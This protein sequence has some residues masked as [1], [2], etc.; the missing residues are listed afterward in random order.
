MTSTRRGDDSREPSVH[1]SSDDHDVVSWSRYYWDQN[2][3]P[4][5]DY[6]A[7]FASLGRLEQLA[8][9]AIEQVLKPFGLGLSRYLLLNTLML[10]ED[11]S[12]PMNR[13]SWHMMV[14]PTTVT[15]VVDQLEKN[16]LV[17][18]KPHPTDRRATLVHITPSGKALAR[19]ASIALAEARFGLPELP[20]KDMKQALS[21][22]RSMRGSAG[23]I[24][25]GK[26]LSESA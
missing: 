13:L 10:T 25:T 23:D 8:S 22:L 17:E 7:L 1:P 18:R 12:R 24:S 19:E 5:G 16:R 21:L 26:S 6:L 2:G 15:V 14:H 3:L 4:A 9:Q 20:A 11:G